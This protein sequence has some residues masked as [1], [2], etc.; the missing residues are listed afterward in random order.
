M[1]FVQL[2]ATIVLCVVFG[3]ISVVIPADFKYIYGF[4]IGILL[5]SVLG[6]L[7]D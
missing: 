6:A 2:L 3:L 1:N 5:T 4:F 7:E